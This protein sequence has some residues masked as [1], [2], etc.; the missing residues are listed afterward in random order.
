[1]RLYMAVT[2]DRYELPIIVTQNAID[3]ARAYG[4]KGN[5]IYQCLKQARI[6]K[7]GV[8]FVKVEMEE[9]I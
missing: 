8:K 9:K 4:L 3:L 7:D 6:I 1:M 2:A 5:C